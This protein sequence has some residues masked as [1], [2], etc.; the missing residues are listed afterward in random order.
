MRSGNGNR[1]FALAVCALS[2]LSSLWADEYIISYRAAVKD[3]VLL[4]ETLNVSRAMQPCSGSAGRSLTLENSADSDLEK[5][6]SNDKEL[7]F[8][9]IQRLPIHIIH[10][11]ANT[12]SQNRSVTIMRL[13]PQCFTVD[14]NDDF[15]RIAPLI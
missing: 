4:N 12:R 3:A 6:L 15:V 9:Y 14:F 7:L 8:D 10:H 13:P 5:I 1:A 11:G 2:T